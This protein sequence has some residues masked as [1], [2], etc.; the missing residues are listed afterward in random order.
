MFKVC[1]KSQFKYED[2]VLN[3]L[4][5]VIDTC[6]LLSINTANSI[7][8]KVCSSFL[9]NVYISIN[10]N[11]F[12]SIKEKPERL[13]TVNGCAFKGDYKNF[14][15][16]YDGVKR[17]VLRKECTDNV[18]LQRH[19]KDF[20]LLIPEKMN[21]LDVIYKVLNRDIEVFYNQRG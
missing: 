1:K 7:S 16:L 2:F 20:T 13:V 5:A 17:F 9:L 19:G 21:V 10:G 4:N 3:K 8:V 11:T 15:S 18:I 14:E 12:I 6:K